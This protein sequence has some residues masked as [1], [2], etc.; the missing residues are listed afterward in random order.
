M[1]VTKLHTC[2]CVVHLVAALCIGDDNR[3]TR[4]RRE[5]LAIKQTKHLVAGS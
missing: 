5:R 1:D 4:S 3:T 2:L